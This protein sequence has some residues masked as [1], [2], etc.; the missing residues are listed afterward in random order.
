MGFSKTGV[1]GISK[2]WGNRVWEGD[3]VGNDWVMGFSRT[4]AMGAG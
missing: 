1:T 2:I 3:V 4:W